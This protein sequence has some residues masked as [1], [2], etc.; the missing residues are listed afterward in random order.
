MVWKSE[1]HIYLEILCINLE[2]EEFLQRHQ[3]ETKTIYSNKRLK[4]AC[5]NLIIVNA[6]DKATQLLLLHTTFS[7]NKYN[8]DW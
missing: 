3:S 8:H 5:L 1:T 6:F 2:E 4:K 7:E